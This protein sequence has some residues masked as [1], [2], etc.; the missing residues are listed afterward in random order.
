MS[1]QQTFEQWYAAQECFATALVSQ[2]EKMLMKIAFIAGQNSGIGAARD[3]FNQVFDGVKCSK[4]TDN[5]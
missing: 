1:E 2:G 5:Q 3:I 4:P